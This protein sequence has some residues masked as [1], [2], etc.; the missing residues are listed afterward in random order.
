MDRISVTKS[1]SR[2]MPR[3]NTDILHGNYLLS[4]RRRKDLWL[5]GFGEA[6]D[7]I[8]SQVTG[9]LLIQIK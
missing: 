2:L 7:A 8:L 3:A 5:H 9:R 4:K 6:K 1:F